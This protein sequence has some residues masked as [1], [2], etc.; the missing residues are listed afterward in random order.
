MMVT[1]PLA[2]ILTNALATCAASAFAAAALEAEQMETDD[3]APPKARQW[4]S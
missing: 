4:T 3:G 1:P 2:S